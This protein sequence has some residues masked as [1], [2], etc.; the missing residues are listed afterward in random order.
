[1]FFFLAAF[2][3]SDKFYTLKA[4][5]IMADLTNVDQYVGQLNKVGAENIQKLNECYNLKAESLMAKIE[6]TEK[7][8]DE[9]KALVRL[10]IESTVYDQVIKNHP[11]LI[12]KRIEHV[13]TYVFEDE[14][15]R[16]LW[17]DKML[18]TLDR[19]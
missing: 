3:I 8:S 4:L 2:V 12:R 15:D 16:D 11:E 14:R 13:A 9:A 1:M 5:N 10:S 6:K 17:L 19:Q 7:L 18:E